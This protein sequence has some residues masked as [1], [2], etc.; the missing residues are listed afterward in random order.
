MMCKLTKCLLLV[1]ISTITVSSAPCSGRL[2][3]KKNAILKRQLPK[4][5]MLQKSLD[6]FEKKFESI[7]SMPWDYKYRRH[8]NKIDW[9]TPRYVGVQ[10]DN[11]MENGYLKKNESSKKENFVRNTE[12]QGYPKKYAKENHFSRS[13]AVKRTELNQNETSNRGNEAPKDYYF[14]V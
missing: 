4:D 2:G 8:T 13:N 11:Q 9:E 5:L 3:S 6:K 7:K 12:K 10:R 1:S 14:E